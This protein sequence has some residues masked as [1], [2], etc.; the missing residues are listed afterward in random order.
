M[1]EQYVMFFYYRK[2]IFVTQDLLGATHILR[3]KLSMSRIV[4]SLLVR[5]AFV[6]IAGIIQ[7]GL[8]DQPSAKL[9]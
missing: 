2:D 6:R 9:K 5:R 7:Y 3:K 1:S 8:S 4:F